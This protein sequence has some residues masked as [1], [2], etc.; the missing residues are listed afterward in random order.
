[1]PAASIVVAVTTLLAA[2]CTKVGPDYERPQLPVP[3]QFRFADAATEASSLADLPWWQVFDDPALQ[4]LVRE[5]VA[6]NLDVRIAA[7][8]VEEL[9]ARAGIVK[10]FLYPQVD[11]A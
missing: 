2:G 11:A 10:S 8:R 5:A 9:R 3:P 7:A 4:A 6:N 1:M